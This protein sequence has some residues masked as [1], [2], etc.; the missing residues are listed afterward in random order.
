MT[1]IYSQ[2]LL[3]LSMWCALKSLKCCGAFRILAISFPLRDRSW[4]LWLGQFGWML[5]RPAAYL[6]TWDFFC[7]LTGAAFSVAQVV[8]GP[9][10]PS[11]VGSSSPGTMLSAVFL[12]LNI[13]YCHS[14]FLRQSPSR[15]KF[16]TARLWRHCH[17]T[18]HRIESGGRRKS[19]VW[20]VGHS[21]SALL[22]GLSALLLHET[23]LFALES[24]SLGCSLRY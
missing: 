7:P 10:L 5:L 16:K 18:S 11:R 3:R 6:P 8:Q 9:C 17:S 22:E 2:T 24:Q 14:S 13:W 21:G 4:I 1:L 15:T 12:W 20:V 23:C 19:W